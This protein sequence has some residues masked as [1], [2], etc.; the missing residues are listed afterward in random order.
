MASASVAGGPLTSERAQQA[1]E[2]LIADRGIPGAGFAAAKDGQIVATAAAGVANIDTGL[3]V[4][5][6]T[7]FQAGS[8]GKTYTAVLVMQLVDEG[9]LDLD[10]P[11]VRHLPDLRFADEVATRT[12][13]A[14]R[15]LNHTGGIDGD[16]LDERGTLY[17]RGDD[18][19]QRY[20][21]GLHDLP[22]M[23]P[24]GKL[25]SYCN[26]GYIVLG[27]LVEVLRDMPFEQV[28]SQRLLQPAGLT[29]TFYFAEDVIARNV[30]AGHI[31]T[32]DGGM[33]VSPIWA[34][35]RAGA[36]AGAVPYTT[37]TD[38]VGFAGVLLR[39]GL[40]AD[41]TRILSEAAVAEMLRPHV[42]CPERELLGGHWGLGVMMRIDPAPAIYGHDG[43]T[44]GQTA[45]LRF[46]PELGIAYGLITNRHQANA[47]F[48]E[49]CNAI[50][51]DWAGIVTPRQRKPVEGLRVDNPERFAG[52]YANVA[53]Q[54]EIG[55]ADGTPT[56]SLRARRDTAEQLDTAPSPLRPLDQDT[57]VA[58]LDIID[59][60][61][62]VAFLE[63]DAAGRPGFLHFGG[64]LYK[65]TAT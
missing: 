53:A 56:M 17:G 16:R 8:I 37:L 29:S 64:R 54:I 59:E 36:S 60:D 25:W 3:R 18:A 9:L 2:Q 61:L 49:L 45:A 58:H 55:L 11:V 24:P 32:P 48:A 27:R 38:L 39:R 4:D 5:D 46:I 63:P 7:I 51:D 23:L 52:T 26:A 20:V 42:E 33:T 34:L 57:F 30:A 41:G 47:V 14:R 35:G 6:T 31:P 50:V 15:L 65:R 13:T 44:M 62:Q 10:A 22:Q 21:A 28:L 12:I 43:N 1:L 40:A 19:V